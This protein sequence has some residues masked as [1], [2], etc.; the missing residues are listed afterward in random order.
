[1]LIG[2][3]IRD[4][5]QEKK[6]SQQELGNL[7]GVTKVS[8]CGYESGTRTPGLDTFSD[9]ADV[10]GTSTDYLLGREIKLVNEDTNKY[11]GSASESDLEILRQFRK[12]P[13]LYKQLMEEPKR[14]VTLINKKINQ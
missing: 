14:M 10:F 5:R 11:V 4:L 9:L 13:T 8:V 3:R 12:Y 1:M 6:M 7:L 2:K